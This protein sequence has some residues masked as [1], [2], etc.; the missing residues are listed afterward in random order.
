[1]FRRRAPDTAPASA[2]GFPTTARWR[3]SL[4]TETLAFF[5]ALFFALACNH[6]FLSAALAGRD[7]GRLA[8]WGFGA[9]ILVLVTAVTFLLLSALLTRWTAKPVLGFLFLATAFAVYF[10]DA[11]GVYLD[12][13]M[14]RNAL[15]T[16]YHEANELFTWSML[17]YLLGYGLLPILLLSRVRIVGAAWRRS[18]LT[19]AGA[20]LLA[21]LVAGAALMLVFQDF[22]SL[23]RNHKEVRYLITP[24]NYL[25]SLLRVTGAEARAA[26]QPRLKIGT[27]ATQAPLGKGAKPALF[28]VVVGETARAANWGLSGYA[29]ETTPELAKL[30]VINFADVSSCGTNTEVSLPCMFS[31]VGRRDYDEDRIRGSE[32]LLHVL[33]HAG[34]KVLWRDNQSGCKGVCEGLPEEKLSDAKVPG[35]CDGERCLDDI[36]LHGLD[37]VLADAAG[38]MVIVMH[39]LGNH[40]PAYFKR[41]PPA[42]RHFQPACENTDLAK[43]TPAEIVNAYDNALRYTDSMLAKTIAFLKTQ[44]QRFDTAMLYVSDHGE[45]LG[46]NNLFLHGIPYSIAPDVQTHVPMVM[47]VSPGFARDA[48]LDLACL[49]ARAQKPVSHDYLFHTVLGLMN[50][51][52]G[53]YE[54][55]Y[56]FSAACR[57]GR[58]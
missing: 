26:D 1:M 10:M 58:A 46:E 51:R 2:A 49:R 3:W 20:V 45:S 56:D 47:W 35:L 50:V 7:L 27:D 57:G 29:R 22:A 48:S 53:V 38:N 43:C 24:A 13:S 23:M 30:D 4:R 8:N 21:L 55:A 11:F 14:L 19:R 5:A 9:A 40:G 25:Y 28:V 52:T 15:R 6:A 17:P 42:F 18:L 39:Q 12:P 37:R 16:D 36:L 41:Y 54:P 34:L 32:S 44:E 33:D 31:A